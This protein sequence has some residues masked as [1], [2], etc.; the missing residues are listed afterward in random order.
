M[1]TQK[2]PI[3]PK[4]EAF[5]DRHAIGETVFGKGAASDSHLVYD[6]RDGRKLRRALR[7]RIEVFMKAYRNGGKS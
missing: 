6:L 4:I 2:D 1:S 7:R 3:L 5:L